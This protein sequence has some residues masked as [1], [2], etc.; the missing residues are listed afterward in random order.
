VPRGELFTRNDIAPPEPDETDPLGEIVYASGT[1][2][3]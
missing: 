1:L 3:R 2:A